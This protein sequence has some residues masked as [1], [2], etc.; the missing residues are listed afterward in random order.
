MQLHIKILIVES[1]ILY[2]NN[3]TSTDHY[4][5][6]FPFPFHSKMQKVRTE[7]TDNSIITNNVCSLIDPL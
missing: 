1:N 6:I 2:L 3:Y 7:E 5:I 4:I